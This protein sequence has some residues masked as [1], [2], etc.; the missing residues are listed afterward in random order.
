MREEQPRV[1]HLGFCTG[2]RAAA[3]ARTNAIQNPCAESGRSG[4][5]ALSMLYEKT[6]RAAG[7]S[8]RARF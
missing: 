1:Q 3:M 2:T 8:E 4:N 7:A 6:M 5:D